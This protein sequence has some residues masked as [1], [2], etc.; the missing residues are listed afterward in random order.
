MYICVC[1]SEWPCVYVWIRKH[2][3][4][5]WVWLQADKPRSEVGLVSLVVKVDWPARFYPF[6]KINFCVCSEMSSV[7]HLHKNTMSM[8]ML[9][10]QSKPSTHIHTHIIHFF[11]LFV[12]VMVSDTVTV[13]KKSPPIQKHYHYQT[14]WPHVVHGGQT[15][16]CSQ[17]E[18]G[19]NVVK[20]RKSKHH[21]LPLIPFFL[22]IYIYRSGNEWD[23][24]I[25]LWV[26]T[27]INV[28]HVLHCLVHLLCN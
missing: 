10:N 7:T 2:S 25:C 22:Y 18:V 1:V 21:Q 26:C 11:F 4:T 17:Q 27:R 3:L 16:G 28:S 14:V 12:P 9:V 13:F 8:I 6:L 5:A 24:G 20:W 23:S 15:S 19:L